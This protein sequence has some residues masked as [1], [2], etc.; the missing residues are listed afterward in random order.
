MTLT[1]PAAT[2]SI[3][4]TGAQRRLIVESSSSELFDGFEGKVASAGVLEG[5]LSSENAQA[6]RNV[7]PHLVPRPVGLSTSAGTGDRLGLATPGHVA[8]FQESGTHLVPVFAQQSAREMDRVGRDPRAVIDDATF[9]AIEGGW[10]GRMAADAD[11]LKTTAD[12]DRCLAAGFTSFTLDPGDVVQHLDGAATQAD[13]KAL[14]WEDL[15]D[16]YEALVA[17]YENLN[18]DTGEG[19]IALSSEDLL[20]AAAKYGKCVALAVAMYRHLVEKAD[21]EVEVEIAVDETADVT[22]PA[23]HVY[24]A[25]ELNRL[26]VRFTGFAPRYIG[27]FEKGVEYIGD[28]RVLEDS[29][30]VHAGIARALGPYKLSLHSGSDKFSIYDVVAET[31]GGLVH[32]KTS[33]TSWLTAL[34]VVVVREPEVFR[35]IYAVSRNAYVDAR[36]SYPVSADPKD[37]PPPEAVADAHLPELLSSIATRQVLHVGYGDVLAVSELDRQIRQLLADNPGEYR[38]RL[39]EHIGR[40]LGPFNDRAVRA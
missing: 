36:E 22:T 1:N 4:G 23:E 9:G 24:F 13:L 8:A 32:L 26:G 25:T 21:R 31:T 35:E 40:H 12:I 33:G 27:D 20:T 37:V 7:F 5:P 17:R 39:R 14:P 15:E 19:S 28:L 11:H 6:A 2:L 30:R 29:L 38:D 34:D 3:T 16:S 18:V 10:Q